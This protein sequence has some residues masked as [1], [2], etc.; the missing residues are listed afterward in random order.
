[1]IQYQE[2]SLKE[3]TDNIDTLK[4]N[5]FELMELK[6]I[7]Q[8]VQELFTDVSMLRL[9]FISHIHIHVY[10]HIVHNGYH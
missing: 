4:K 1:M 3:V 5:L 8:H 9:T 7:L 2:E 6:C 10:I